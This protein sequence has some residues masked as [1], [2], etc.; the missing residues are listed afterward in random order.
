MSGP[1]AALA[2]L[3]ALDAL[4]ARD[5]PAAR[6]D[7][8]V[9]A[10]S[11][12][13]FAVTVASF[14][15][16][17]PLRLVPLA[18]WPVALA[19][20]G[21]VPWRPLLARLALASPFALGVAAFE[22]LLD[23]APAALGGLPAS[24]GAVAAL[25]I[26]LKFALALSAA[27]VLVATTGFDAVCAA[28]RR[29]GA[30]RAV[31]TQLLL[32]YRYLFVLADETART[33]RAH[34]LRSPDRPRPALRTTGTLLGA[35]LLRTLARGERVH[36]AMLGRGFDGEL[37]LGRPGRLRRADVA[38]AAATALLLV[39]CRAIDVPAALGAALGRL[40]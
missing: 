34:A 15:R 40:G 13:A 24:A 4:A 33:L 17:E 21:G 23:R 14:G 39:A 16:L 28:L 35:L 18:A 10:L 2:R 5:T 26:L 8:R 29:L 3:G 19:A 9:K 32:L 38:F 30:P 1:E 36:A 6:L 37:R 27:L 25:T 31:V 11:A 12:L 20:L 7:P 22:P